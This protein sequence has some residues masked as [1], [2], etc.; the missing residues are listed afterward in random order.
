MSLWE[1]IRNL[2]LEV[3]GY[4]LEGL[5]HEISSALTRQT[6]VVRLH[7]AGVSGVGEDVTYAEAEQE[8]FQRAGAVLDLAGQHTLESLSPRF[9]ALPDYRRWAFESA[10]LDL[11]LGQEGRALHE[12]VGREPSPVRFVVSTSLPDGHARRL[13]TLLELHSDLRF[14]VDAE[15]RWGEDIVAEL[16]ELDA[17]DIVDFKEAYVWRDAGRT[18]PPSLYRLLVEALPEAWLEDPSLED[19]EKVSILEPHRNR[20]TWDA[21]IHSVADV[22][23]LR[24]APR[25]LNVKPSRF[26]SLR[27]LLD[28]YDTCEERGIALYGGGQFE[29]GPGRGQIQYLASLFHPDSPNDVAPGRYNETEPVPTLPGSPLAPAPEAKGFRWAEIASL[30]A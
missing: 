30:Q 9:E 17:V 16:V 11:A 4:S 26:G 21:V 27:R 25:T 5:S 2:P 1:L 20:V 13:R 15:A 14:K 7:G 22:D 23:A 6:T 12:V 18:P 10:A 19:P 24:W 28:F 8:E 3:D 29:L